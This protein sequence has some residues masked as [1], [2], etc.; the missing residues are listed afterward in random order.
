LKD[1][2]AVLATVISIIILYLLINIW[3]YRQ[4]KMDPDRVYITDE[5]SITLLHDRV[6]ITDETSITL[7]HDMVYTTDE[8]SITLLHDG[9]Y[10]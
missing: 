4:D 7:L 9:I 6:Y 5:T 2:A 1:N 10:Y 3:A 8:T